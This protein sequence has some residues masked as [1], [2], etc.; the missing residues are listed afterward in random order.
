MPI[1]DIQFVKKDILKNNYEIL[2]KASYEQFWAQNEIHINFLYEFCNEYLGFDCN[3]RSKD[4]DQNLSERIKPVNSIWYDLSLHN[5]E[6]LLETHK[7]SSLDLIKGAFDPFEYQK[8]CLSVLNLLNKKGVA[9][10][11]IPSANCKAIYKD[12]KKYGYYVNGIFGDHDER[13]LSDP[14]D[15]KNILPLHC[16]YVALL[17]SKIKTKHLFIWTEM[18]DFKVDNDLD[19]ISKKLLNKVLLNESKLTKRDKINDELIFKG[20]PVIY[21]SSK[22]VDIENL[23][24]NAKKDALIDESFSTFKEVKLSDIA[25]LISDY[26]YY[27][28]RILESIKVKD[29]KAILDRDL[30]DSTLESDNTLDDDAKKL[31]KD[32][33]ELVLISRKDGAGN[34]Y[35]KNE[36]LQY[37]NDLLIIETFSE[38][39]QPPFI[40]IYHPKDWSKGDYKYWMTNDEKREIVLLMINDS[41][42]INLEYVIHFLK[43]ERGVINAN[44]ALNNSKNVFNAWKNITISIPSIDDQKIIVSA[45]NSSEKIKSRVNTLEK[46]LIN[47]PLNAS[48]TDQELTEMVSRLDMLSESDQIA[49]WIS[50]RGSET[51][52]IEF[53]Q[54]LMLDIKTQ[55]SEKRLETTSFKTIVGFINNNGGN[56]VIGVSDG[57]EVTGME[58]ELEKFHK[59][60]HDKFKITFG[61]KISKRIG[62][63]FLN[64]ISYEFISLNGKYVFR[65]KCTKSKNKCFLDGEDFYVRRHAYTEKLAG[66]ELVKYIEEH[67]DPEK[68]IEEG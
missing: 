10:I 63:E 61:N 45:I 6:N 58:H 64:N 66:P 53:K 60:S 13:D 26:D 22:F 67:Y 43:S 31:S 8:D 17:I 49:E 65:V 46:N 68:W 55:T 11:Y 16:K 20:H 28:V 25:E 3:N 36:A 4:P 37:I 12:L 48:E 47:N 42:M 7:Q 62:K 52:E 9:Y 18:S 59:R 27:I 44:L 32:V 23:Y 24:F 56:L 21:S 14:I 41:S 33:Q 35:K 40:E 19:S 34:S 15:Q 5:V 38:E 51:D 2:S 30:L 57:G 1:A 54:T 39:H 50:R 29:N